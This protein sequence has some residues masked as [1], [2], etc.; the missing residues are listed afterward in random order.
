MI[1]GKETSENH[2]KIEKSSNLNIEKL[3]N[4]SPLSFGE[5]L[6]NFM[7]EKG[8]KDKDLAWVGDTSY[9][10]KLK[11]NK[12][13]QPD[14]RQVLR[15]GLELELNIDEFNLLLKSIGYSDLY[16]RDKTESVIIWGLLHEKSTQEIK[17]EIKERNLNL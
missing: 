9:L 11:K 10:A 2:R 14:R 3:E 5:V 1:M 13:K 4:M 15:L 17:K 16:T 7:K 6:E 8:K 12:I